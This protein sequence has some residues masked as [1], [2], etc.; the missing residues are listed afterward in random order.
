MIEGFMKFLAT[1]EEKVGS[2][3]MVGAGPLCRQ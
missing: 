2:E 3:R 1:E